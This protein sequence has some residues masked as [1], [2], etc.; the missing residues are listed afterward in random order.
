MSDKKIRH[1]VKV[2][3]KPLWILLIKR[4]I[5]KQKLREMTD[6]AP[7]TFTKMINNEHVALD[8]LARISL[9]LGCGI[10]D[11]VEIEGLLDD[12]SDNAGGHWNLGGG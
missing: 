11:I 7:S 4:D 5:P 10:D 6:I 2:N 8:V 9:A 1:H 3:Y 12:G